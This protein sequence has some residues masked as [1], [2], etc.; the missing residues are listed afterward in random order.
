MLII[1]IVACPDLETTADEL[2][3]Y[4]HALNHIFVPQDIYMMA[5]HPGNDLEPV[6][7]LEN[8]DWESDNE[9]LMVLIQPFEELEKASSNL[10]KIGFYKT[11]PQDYYESTVNKRK[12]YRRLLCEE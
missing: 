5:S 6:E 11:W 3:N 7:F 2:D 12:T 1:C 9:F 10:N 4:V 8:T